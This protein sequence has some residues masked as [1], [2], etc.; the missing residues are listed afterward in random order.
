MKLDTKPFGWIEIDERQLV[1]FPQGI[2]G[3]EDHTRWALLD[4]Q[5]AP[6]Y[7]LQSLHEAGL[8]FV[9]IDPVFFR[10]DYKADVS[11]EDAQVLQLAD[12]A[13]L[14]VFSIVTIPEDHNQMTANLQGPLLINKLARVG[15]QGIQIDNC[16]KVRHRIMDEL[17]A[18]GG[19]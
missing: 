13:D 3:F 8:A 5:Q 15:K 18:Q 6:F 12:N 9:L 1:T 11:H 2:F 16:W 17:A 7:W 4:S 10:P 14:L 19:G